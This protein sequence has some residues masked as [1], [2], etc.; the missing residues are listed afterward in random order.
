MLELMM[1]DYTMLIAYVSVGLAV[2]VVAASKL[3]K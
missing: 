1:I 2:G 3:M